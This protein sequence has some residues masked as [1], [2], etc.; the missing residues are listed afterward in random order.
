MSTP[1]SDKTATRGERSENGAYC[2][3]SRE[4]GRRR[5]VV[6][7]V[8]AVFLLSVAGIISVRVRRQIDARIPTIPDVSDKTEAFRRA[9]LKADRRS[10]AAPGGEEGVGHLGLLY[11]ANHMYEP[12][13]ACYRLATELDPDNA[14]WAYHLAV[15]LQTTGHGGK[16]L[17]LLRAAVSAAEDYVPARLK[18]ADLLLKHGEQEQAK[19][20][21]QTCLK[22]A[23]SDPYALLGL[24]RIAVDQEDWAAATSYLRRAVRADPSFGAGHRL[25]A[26]VYRKTG[27]DDAADL[28]QARANK[29]SRF[30]AAPDPWMQPLDDL[31]FDPDYL[32]VRADTFLRTGDRDRALAL[33]ERAVDAAPELAKVHHLYGKAMRETGSMDVARKHL[34]RAID[35]APDEE[36]AHVGMGLWYGMQGQLDEAEAELRKA[37]EINPVSISAYHNLG[38]V[39]KE[40]GKDTAA[41]AYYLRACELSELRF[42]KAIASYVG[43]LDR[44]GQH[45][46][47]IAFLEDVLQRRPTASLGW[48]LLAHVCANMNDPAKAEEVLRKGLALTPLDPEL[49]TS[50]AWCLAVSDGA[51]AQEATEAVR[52]VQGALELADARDMPRCLAT[53]AAA[54]AREGRFPEAIGA[55]RN[56]IEL[57][58]K[59]GDQESV[60]LYTEYIERFRASQPL[61]TISGG[62]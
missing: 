13:E 15:L 49:R 60:K 9:L 3:A 61:T 17:D 40:H 50:L 20:E 25:L 54:R 39:E 10:R 11:H 21:Y 45:Q 7:I 19:Q 29:C 18:L 59:H 46:K 28:A 52:L 31:C 1:K 51:T 41:A 42:D 5:Q 27:R 48:R 58:R 32:C 57:A 23:S 4:T 8:I 35:L 34:Q 56:A 2:D 38:M 55:I 43:C 62:L 33:A 22:Q 47:A 14:R 37:L 44:L 36:D 26:T 16:I 53:L 30:A 12:A 6:V 24:A